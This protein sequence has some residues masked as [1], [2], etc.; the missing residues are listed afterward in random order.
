MEPIRFFSHFFI[1][2]LIQF[3]HYYHRSELTPFCC[4]KLHS[5]YNNKKGVENMDLRLMKMNMKLDK[6]HR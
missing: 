5:K 1:C 2:D 6:N 3:S 4:G